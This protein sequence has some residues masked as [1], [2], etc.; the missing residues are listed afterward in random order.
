MCPF[1]QYLK[2]WSD[3]LDS[4]ETNFQWQ[5]TIVCFDHFK[6][7][8][9]TVAQA[10]S[11]GS[12]E[13]SAL[14]LTTR[15]KPCGQPESS[16]SVEEKRVTCHMPLMQRVNGQMNQHL[17]AWISFNNIFVFSFNSTHTN[18]F[19]SE[20]ILRLRFVFFIIIFFFAGLIF[21]TVPPRVV[22]T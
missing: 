12:M 18:C 9:C 19:D 17:H 15:L 20:P 21:N 4:S 5:G 11:A 13:V 14:L 6:Y 3:G 1:G 16:H 10:V 2:G 7:G 8:A 22:K